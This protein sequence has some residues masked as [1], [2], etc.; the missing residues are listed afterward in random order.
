MVRVPKTHCKKGHRLI[1][2]NLKE[3]EIKR[4]TL[5]G[6][7]YS[8]IARTCVK[9]E[10]EYHRRWWLSKRP[11][12]LKK[13]R[14]THCP[15]GHEL[16]GDNLYEREVHKVLPSGKA[17]ITVART[18]RICARAATRK[19]YQKNHT[20]RPKVIKVLKPKTEYKKT[21]PKPKDFCSKGH[22]MSGDNLYIPK[23]RG[24]TG[25]IPTRQC[26]ACRKDA[27]RRY[28]A[29]NPHRIRPVK[30]AEKP[31]SNE[32]DSIRKSILKIK[33]KYYI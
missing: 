23:K 27:A 11:L 26:R 29:A 25:W 16:S 32:M 7:A 24:A 33:P 18:C 13:P 14:V 1:G 20:P 5:K 22:P 6:V 12:K 10:K 31:A 30:T 17:S 28:Q 8:T 3:R 21:G 9:C 19:S 4:T 2:D 15:R